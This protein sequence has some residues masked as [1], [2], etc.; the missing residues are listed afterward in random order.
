[1]DFDGLNLQEAVFWIR[2]NIQRICE[3]NDVEWDLESWF[4][5]LEPQQRYWGCGDICNSFC[6]FDKTTRIWT[7]ELQKENGK[8]VRKF[9][10]ERKLEEW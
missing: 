3:E 10:T 9:K 6:E 4:H 7:E 8:R 2:D 5:F 1:M